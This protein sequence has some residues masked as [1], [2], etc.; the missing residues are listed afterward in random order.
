[1][2]AGVGGRALSGVARRCT[3]RGSPGH[4]SGLERWRLAPAPAG[5]GCVLGDLGTRLRVLEGKPRSPLDVGDESGTKLGVIG[6]LS[7]VGRQAQKR[8][9][10]E[11]AARV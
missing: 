6:E 5:Y 7:V 9:E 8:R 3:A 4:L 11:V 1:M 2:P 10:A